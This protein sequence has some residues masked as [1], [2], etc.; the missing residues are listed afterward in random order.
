MLAPVT[1]VH[2]G[3][4]PLLALNLESSRIYPEFVRELQDAAG[5]DVGYRACGTVLVARDADDNAALAHLYSFQ[6]Q[7]GLAVKRLRAAECKAMEPALA[8]GV[9]GGILVEGDHQI[10]NRALSAALEHACKSEGVD[11]LTGKVTTLLSGPSGRVGGIVTGDGHQTCGAVVLAGGC[12]SGLIEG[13][14]PEV[15]SAVRPV[16]G[17]LVVLRGSGSQ[18][19]IEHNIRGLDA[20][21]VM[22]SD[23][24]LIVGAT[25]EEMGFDT[26]VTAGAVYELLRTAYEL[27]PGVS[28]LELVEATSGLRPGS[29]DNAPLIGQTSMEGLVVATGHFR[30]GILLVPVTAYAVADL[31]ATGRAPEKTES[32]SP[33]RFATEVVA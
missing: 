5:M 16:K 12:W 32:F 8:P 15:A 4:E 23:G 17:Q 25:V 33:L 21:M 28:E 24:R 1:E 18:P 10:D 27:V 14:A 7:L 9:R 31:L 20:Y 2:Y 6:S 26:R 29:P 22:R 11:L 19:L 3:E 13:V 30:N